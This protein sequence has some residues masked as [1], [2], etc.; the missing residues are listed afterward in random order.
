[1]ILPGYVEK[2]CW[3]RSAFRHTPRQPDLSLEVLAQ[4]V[5]AAVFKTVE[6]YVN[7][8][9]GGF[10]S[11]A[12][13][14]LAMLVFAVCRTTSR[15]FAQNRWE[16]SRCVSS[17][18]CCA[19]SCVWLL[20]S[21]LRRLG[22]LQSKLSSVVCRKCFRATWGLLPIPLQLTPDGIASSKSVSR[23][24]PANQPQAGLI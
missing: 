4:L 23:N 5:L 17:H 8:A 2:R 3:F 12:L 16:Q 10:D 15:H 20:R 21:I 24:R 1:M 13:P 18:R 11:H 7:R 9:I 19:S 22:S 14:L 6:S